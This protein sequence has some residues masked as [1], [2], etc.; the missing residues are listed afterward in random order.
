MSSRLSWATD[1]GSVLTEPKKKKKKTGREEGSKE[2]NNIRGRKQ[3][4][5]ILRLA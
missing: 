4:V 3:E 1:W 5:S 2:R